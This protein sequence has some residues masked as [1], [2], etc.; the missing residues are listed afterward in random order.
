[1]TWAYF[2]CFSGAGGDMILAALLDAGADADRLADHLSR[3]GLHGVRPVVARA[4]RKGLAATS[5]TVEVP[6]GDQP[7]RHLPEI[8]AMID[9]ADLPRR[10]GENARAVFAR[11]AEAEARVHGI[12]PERVHFH[13]VGAA[14]SIIDIVG[15]CVALELLGIDRLVCSPLPL[16]GGTVLCDHGELPVPTPATVELLRG[17][18]T[19]PGPVREELTTPTAAAILST[20]AASFGPAPAME[21]AAVGYGAGSREFGPLPNVLRVLLGHP[22]EA[23][24]VDAVVELTANLDDC[25]GE[26]L[27]AALDALLAGG[28]LDAWACPVTM[29]KSRPAWQLSALCPPERADAAAR[30]FFEQTTTFGLRRR[31]C[32]RQTLRREHRPVETP[33]GPVRVKLGRLDGRL[34]QVAPE[35]ADAL[36]AAEAHHVPVADVLAAADHAARREMAR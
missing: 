20:L 9:A 26:V 31:T 34:V 23:G 8:L 18:P 10:A 14:D 11:L 6:P 21:L 13:E 33:F 16:G 32:S 2:D 29:K 15:A 3:L 27:G 5:L 17:V 28:C 36:A 24:D 30:I 12:E 22:A 4:Q 7:H 19:V 25:T 35:F 1:M